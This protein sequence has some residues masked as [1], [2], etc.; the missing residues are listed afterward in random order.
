MG[1]NAAHSVMRYID[2]SR[3]AAQPMAVW[4]PTEAEET[5]LPR[6][7]YQLSAAANGAIA[8]GRRPVALISHGSGGTAFGHHELGAALARRGWIVVAP[9]HVGNSALDDSAVG[10]QRMWADR[11]GQ[12]SAALDAALAD[13]RLGPHMDATRVAGVGFSAGGSTM[14]MLAGARGEPDRIAWHCAHIPEDSGFATLV[15]GGKRYAGP[16][17]D[18]FDPRFRAIVVLAPVGA[19]F[20]DAALAGVSVPAQIWG[21]ELDALVAPT[22]HAKR[23]ATQMGRWADYR[24]AKGAGHF[25][26]MSPLPTGAGDAFGA[27][28]LDPPGF[29]RRAFIAAL[30][31]EIAVFLE[32]HC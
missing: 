19:L 3:K 7:P 4:W 11:P 8:P 20:S 6:G 23:V 12:I 9:N 31:P 32:A 29:D 15:R 10:T 17:V 16:P 13:A 2:P 24:E 27:A 14:L 21:A 1:F 22:Y 26:F 25:S 30:N 18:G 28:A 5:I